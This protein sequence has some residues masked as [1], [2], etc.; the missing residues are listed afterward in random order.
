MTSNSPATGPFCSRC[1]IPI[2]KGIWCDQ[3][4]SQ[5]QVEFLAIPRDKFLSQGATRI[6]IKQ[7]VITSNGQPVEVHVTFG[8]EKPCAFCGQIF[9]R[10]EF[11]QEHHRAKPKYCERHNCCLNDICANC[12]STIDRSKWGGYA[13]TSGGGRSKH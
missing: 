1:G 3:H 10:E 2:Q 4:V 9:G 8:S 13:N 5:G 7:S 6:E 11:L 12:P